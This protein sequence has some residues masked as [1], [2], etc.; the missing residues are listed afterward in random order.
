MPEL[1]SPKPGDSLAGRVAER[2]RARI[3]HDYGRAAEINRIMDKSP[4]WLSNIFH[5]RAKIRLDDLEPI[6]SLLGGDPCDLVD[7]DVRTVV[8]VSGPEQDLLT[9]FRLLPRAQRKEASD[10]LRWILGRQDAALHRGPFR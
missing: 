5:G 3:G 10:L 9:A 1:H 8:K 2:I 4:G 6:A 7:D